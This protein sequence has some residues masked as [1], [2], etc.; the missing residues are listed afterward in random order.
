MKQ[1][2]TWMKAKYPSIY[3]SFHPNHH[4]NF[5]LNRFVTWAGPSAIPDFERAAPQIHDF[6]D[7]KRE[8]LALAAEAVAQERELNAAF[9]YRAAEFFMPECDPQKAWAYDQF[10]TLM[11]R[12]FPIPP[13]DRFQIPY[14]TGYLPAIRLR[15][16]NSRGT[17]VVHGGFDSFIEEFLPALLDL[18]DAGYEVILFEGPGQGAALKKYHLLMTHQWEKPVKAILDYFHLDDVTLIGI[19]LGGYLATRAAAFERRIRL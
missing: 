12:C 19:S 6:M 18:R 5:Q 3:Y 1:G 15:S 14:E 9:Y 17:L 13:E 16:L 7:W 11:G 4:L 8:M 10:I 2:E